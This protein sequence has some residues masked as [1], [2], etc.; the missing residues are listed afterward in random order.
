[1]TKIP[2]VQSVEFSSKCKQASDSGDHHP[3]AHSST[4]PIEIDTPA[5][6]PGLQHKQ[7]DPEFEAVEEQFAADIIQE[8]LLPQSHFPKNPGLYINMSLSTKL[9]RK[10]CKIGPCQPGIKEPFPTV[11]FR[12]KFQIFWRTKCFGKGSM[13]GEKNW[14][15]F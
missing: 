4:Q 3:A 13:K 6:A 1:M 2:A 14:L 15:V 12:R 8:P 5:A 7:T 10:L 9:I 11:E